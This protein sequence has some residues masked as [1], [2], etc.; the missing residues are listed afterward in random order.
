MRVLICG[1]RDPSPEV[2]DAVWNW[3]MEHCEAGDVVIHG[4]ARGVDT[5]AMIA[6][7]TIPGVKHLPF[8]ADWNSHGKAAGP[9]RNSRMLKEGKPDLVVAFPGG[10]GTADMVRQA[11][12]AGVEVAEVLPKMRSDG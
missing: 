8:A 4:A 10:R 9:I 11:R 3:V 5:Q 12:L 1:G 6:A 7:Q 2:C